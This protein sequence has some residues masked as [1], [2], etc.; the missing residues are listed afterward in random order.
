[1][2]NPRPS[3]RRAATLA[4]G[5]LVA[6]LLPA[7]TVAGPASAEPGCTIEQNGSLLPFPAPE[8][9]V[10]DDTTPPDTTITK[11]VPDPNKADYIKGKSVTYT[12]AAV[13]SDGDPGP[14]SYMCRLDGATAGTWK[15]CGDPDGTT[16]PQSVTYSD[17]DDLKSSGYR[18]R[19]YA[20]DTP[21]AANT[22]SDGSL[23]GGATE[24]PAMPDDD[25]AS[26]ASA[27]FKVD[28]ADP[29]TFIFGEPDTF[30]PIRP[31]LP[32]V[33][34]RN[35]QVRLTSSESRAGEGATY[36]CTLND[37]KVPCQEG[38]TSLKNLTPGNKTFEA[39]ATDLAG[40]SSK[41]PAKIVFAVPRN[42]KTTPGWRQVKESGYFAAD[43]LEARTVGATLVTNPVQVREL[44][45]IAPAGPNL[46]RI[47]LQ[48]GNGQRRTI[49][50]FAKTFTRF[51]VYVIRDEFSP[52]ASGKITI[53]VKS[54]GP[55]KVARIDAL[56]IQP[57]G[58]R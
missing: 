53:R 27:G 44:R 48:I 18:F 41:K 5:I 10:C 42:L 57:V 16:T 7:L 45:L 19:V 1:M 14:W 50:L 21:D 15:P 56:L 52:L 43:Y 23:F 6:G 29:S 58:G 32:M 4:A 54:L 12:F 26:P 17:L 30:D 31:E 35:I 24:D 38:F 33:T 9:P 20:I 36:A 28:T 8:T 22:W 40:N 11:T 55:N 34:S 2:S 25:S 47:D 37:V 39:S 49:S 46:G 13:A 3:R 51:K